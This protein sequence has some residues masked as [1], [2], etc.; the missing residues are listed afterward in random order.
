[1]ESASG[2]RTGSQTEGL[3]G[4]V[5]DVRYRGPDGREIFPGPSS[6]NVTHSSS[7][8]SSGR[9]RVE[10]PGLTPGAQRSQYA[11]WERSGWRAIRPNAIRRGPVTKA[12]YVS[13]STPRS[14]TGPS[15]AS[16]RS[17]SDDWSPSGP[18]T[19]HLGAS[20]ASMVR[21]APLS[22]TPSRSTGWR[23]HPEG[24]PSSDR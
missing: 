10:A 8:L 6:P 5:Y 2:R 11:H 9:R 3:R 13:T 7:R 19:W 14:V 21:Y 1:V 23:G 12:R 20:A 22:T 4:R 24:H 18:R 17:I 16:P 15:G